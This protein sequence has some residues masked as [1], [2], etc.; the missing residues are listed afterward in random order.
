MSYIITARANES[1]LMASDTRLNYF[2]DKIINGEKYQEIVAVADCIR[3]TFFI[4]KARI[5]IQFLGIG[6]FPDV[7]DEEYP[8]SHFINKLYD[9]KY[10]EDFKTNAQTIFNFLKKISKQGNN[11][12]YVKG[13]ISR[14]SKN[15]ESYLCIFNTYNDNFEIGEFNVGQFVD[16]EDNSNPFPNIEAEA[17]MEINRRIN[18]ASEKKY[19]CIGGPI[20]ILKITSKEG[21]FIQENTR[22]FNGTKR[23]LVNHFNN[24]I[25]KINGQILQFYHLEKY[26]F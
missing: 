7:N 10:D 14:F 13:V 3:K 5:G 15:D 8:L 4:K 19:W 9:E 17:I 23:K 20:E 25:K 1:I 24:D 2:N 22:L 12:Q 11:R 18:K 6:Y 26:R 16:S 21:I